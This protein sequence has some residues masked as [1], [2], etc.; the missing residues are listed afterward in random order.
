MFFKQSWTRV[1]FGPH[2]EN[3][4]YLAMFLFFTRLNSPVSPYSAF[5]LI[6]QECLCLHIQ[7]SSIEQC[8][9]KSTYCTLT[10]RQR[11]HPEKCA[12]TLW[13][14]ALR[15]PVSI[16]LYL[17]CLP[18]DIPMHFPTTYTMR[19]FRRASCKTEE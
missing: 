5:S 2:G 19:F 1:P 11:Y 12:S 14:L 3:P 17:R 18:K 8:S 6:F 13:R 16:P 9:S 4:S 10:S 7:W 15:S